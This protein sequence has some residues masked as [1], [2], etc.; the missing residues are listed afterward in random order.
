MRHVCLTAFLGLSVLGIAEVQARQIV[1]PN[2]SPNGCGG[3]DCIISSYGV[4]TVA[5]GAVEL[6]TIAFNAGLAGGGNARAWAGPLGVL[7]G[8]AGIALGVVNLDK[9]N[10]ALALG[11]VNIGVG[12]V[13]LGLGLKEWL[14]SDRASMAAARRGEPRVQP[15]YEETWDGRRLL[16]V[17]LRF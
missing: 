8:G 13:T 1:P 9:E 11:I 3:D 10:E 6:F 12:A 17:R 16:G 15:T 2:P 4:A 7:A 5:T 14:R